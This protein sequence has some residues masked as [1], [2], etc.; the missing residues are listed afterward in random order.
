MK[1]RVL[2]LILILFI[3]SPFIMAQCTPGSQTSPGIYPDVA[4]GIANAYVDQA[5]SQTFTVVAPSDTVVM[6]LPVHINS[7]I[8]TGNSGLTSSMHI[9]CVPSNC[10]FP[11][12]SK[13][14]AVLSGMP[15][16]ADVGNH[17]FMIFVDYYT[18]LA[19]TSPVKDTV[20]GYVLR[21]FPAQGILENNTT[22]FS[23]KAN[24]P[25]PFEKYTEIGFTTPDNETV[26]LKITDLLGRTKYTQTIQAKQGENT[27]K[28]NASDLADGIYFYSIS[29]KKQTLTRKMTINK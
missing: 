8:I 28:Y 7:I 18:S 13:N 19:P 26:T 3:C 15:V 4:T 22:T 12:G 11:G 10:T 27:V 16:L 25:N 6:G 2:S 21:V 29:N 9:T 17:P 24:V 5:Y 1:K 20:T 23:L 14:C